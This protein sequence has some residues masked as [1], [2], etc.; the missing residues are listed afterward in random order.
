MSMRSV[1]N[2]DKNHIFSF[3][4]LLMLPYIPHPP[5]N[6]TTPLRLLADGDL[7]R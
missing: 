2:N 7:G 5:W 1:K 6:K 3:S 4:S